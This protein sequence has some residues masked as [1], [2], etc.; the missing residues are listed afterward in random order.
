[1]RFNQITT[2]GP[3]ALQG[4]PP[5]FVERRWNPIAGWQ[6]VAPERASPGQFGR[7]GNGCDSE[8]P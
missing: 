5:F 8:C 4:V 3:D 2:G 1:M 6:P 7:L